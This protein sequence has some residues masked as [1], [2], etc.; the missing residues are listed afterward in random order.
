[1]AG[2]QHFSPGNREL[3]QI[4]AAAANLQIFIQKVGQVNSVCP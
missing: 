2:T 4:D 3:K 1:M